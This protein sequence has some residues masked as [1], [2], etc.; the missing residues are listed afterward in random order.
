MGTT[1]SQ[2]IATL[3]DA[4]N[5]GDLDAAIGLVA[6]DGVDHTPVPGQ[7]PGREGWKGKW[8]YLMSAFSDVSFTIEQ[9]V[10]QGDT[11]ATRYVFRGTHTGDFLGMPATGKSFEVLSLDMVRV[12]DGQIVDH[13]GLLDMPAV[14]TQLGLMPAPA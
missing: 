11:V 13:W 10:E 4:M 5:R 7:G 8:E 1:P 6:E 12:R 14:M 9:S 3:I 2:V